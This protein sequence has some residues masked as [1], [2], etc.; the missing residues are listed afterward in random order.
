MILTGLMPE[1]GPVILMD[2]PSFVQNQE[3]MALDGVLGTNDMILFLVLSNNMKRMEKMPG[4]ALNADAVRN[5]HGLSNIL[6][7]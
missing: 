5:S 1:I 4:V 2:S 3:I 6:N 7:V